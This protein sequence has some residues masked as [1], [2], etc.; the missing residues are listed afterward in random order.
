MI[1]KAGQ[2]IAFIKECVV[3]HGATP[4]TYIYVREGAT[5]PLKRVAQVKM[6]ED[7][8]GR[9]IILETSPILVS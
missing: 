3:S 6:M 8:R 9:A 7:P 4:H 2:L 5:G 1:D